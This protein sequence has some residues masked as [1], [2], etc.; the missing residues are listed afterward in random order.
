[1]VAFNIPISIINSQL[2]V[3]ELRSTLWNSAKNGSKIRCE[4][5]SKDTLI[6]YGLD[7]SSKLHQHSVLGQTVAQMLLGYR[8]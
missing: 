8:V 6:D 5:S 1:V 7:V 2:F 3:Y 4:H